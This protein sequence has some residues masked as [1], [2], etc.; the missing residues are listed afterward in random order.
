MLDK[1]QLN[2]LIL[3]DY[4]AEELHELEKRI[5]AEYERRKAVVRDKAY[6][7]FIEAYKELCK[8]CPNDEMWVTFENDD[9]DEV[10]IDLLEAISEH[11]DKFHKYKAGY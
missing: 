2:E 4:S 9:G 7:N 3:S 10:D 1:A 11:M 8:N 6:G 5:C